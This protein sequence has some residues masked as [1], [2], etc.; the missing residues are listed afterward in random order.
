MARTLNHSTAFVNRFTEIMKMKSPKSSSR[1]DTRA[2]QSQMAQASAK[3]KRLAEQMSRR[4]GLD[5]EQS[6]QAANVK[7]RLGVA[8]PKSRLGAVPR[9]GR[10]RGQRGGT[11]SR[12]GSPRWSSQ[13]GGSRGRGGGGASRGGSRGF[14]RNSQGGVRGNARGRAGGRGRGRGGRGG[15][16]QSKVS[17]E[18]LDSELDSYMNVGR[19][20]DLSW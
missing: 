20:D 11:L 18:D 12:I 14:R 9:L 8:S 1:Q 3:N 4:T 16:G 5:N 10:S 7:S 2:S 17:K 19:K 13:L 15:S 6:G